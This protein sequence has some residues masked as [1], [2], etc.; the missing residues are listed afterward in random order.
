[1][2]RFFM[3]F[4]VCALFVLTPSVS[5]ADYHSS[6]RLVP[7]NAAEITH[8]PQPPV[9][10]VVPSSPNPSLPNYGVT[11]V[12][13]RPPL[14][15]AP[16][17]EAVAVI[18]EAGEGTREVTVRVIVTVNGEDHVIEIPAVTVGAIVQAIAAPVP[19]PRAPALA[20]VDLT[21]APSAPVIPQVARPA[22][23]T[24]RMPAPDGPG[25]YRVQVGS[26]ARTALAQNCFNRLRSAGFSPAFERFGSMYRVVIPGIRAVEMSDV[27]QRLGNAGFEEAWLRREN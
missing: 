5:R 24:P 27:A 2:K 23:M 8:V 6:V 22:V 19:T 25:I 20:P 15:A 7:L 12:P 17:I 11:W 16:V 21:P 18:P 10:T 26:F 1:M 4:L 13:T 9:R 14:E 3:S